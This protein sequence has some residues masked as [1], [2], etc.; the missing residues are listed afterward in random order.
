MTAKDHQ[1]HQD[2]CCGRHTTAIHPTQEEPSSVISPG[3]T[4]WNNKEVAAYLN[5]KESTIR[6]W[7]HIRYVPHIKFRGAVRFR[8]ADIDAWLVRCAGGS[9]VDVSAYASRILNETK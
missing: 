6:N 5:V 4:L 8:K 3:E 2:K 1:C 7:V 9:K